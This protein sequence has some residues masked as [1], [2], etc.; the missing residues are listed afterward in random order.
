MDCV[1]ETIDE[2]DEVKKLLVGKKNFDQLGVQNWSITPAI[3]S[4]D[5]MWPNVAHL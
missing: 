3:P 1:Q 2:F 5:I 4:H